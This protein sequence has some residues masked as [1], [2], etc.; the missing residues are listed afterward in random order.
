VVALHGW[1]RTHADF[2]PALG[3]T[4]A[5]GPLPVIAPDLP[6]FGVTPEP[7]EAWGTDRYADAV[8]ALFD[9][10]DV[11]TPAV[12]VGHSFGGR[13]AVALAARRPDV[14]RA[15]VLTGVPLL[16]S[17]LRQR[18]P[19]R[20]FRAAKTLH[21]WGIVSDDR[22]ERVRRRHGSP[23]YRSASGVMRGVL[24]KV[25]SESY[26]HELAALRCPV[27]LIW[28]DDDS[29]A[30]LAV[31]EAVAAIVPDASLTVSVGAGHLLPLTAP[32]ALRLG[33][34]RALTRAAQTPRPLPERS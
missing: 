14:V 26:E 32:D 10:G 33:V 9:A 12:V 4:A 8:G 7:P 25:V 34:E 5:G 1:A 24:V 23:D 29:E 22:M 20:A 16:P 18:R 6:G 31:A 13:V 3:P 2:A 30:S 28:G 27:E 19:P 17:R 15:L 21:R 11:D